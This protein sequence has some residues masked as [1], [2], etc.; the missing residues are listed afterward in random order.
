MAEAL[1][2]LVAAERLGW[3]EIQ[4]LIASLLPD[5]VVLPGYFAE[6]WSAKD[7]LAHVAGWLSEA[8]LALEQIRVGTF[9]ERAMDVEG[10]N[11]AFLAAN[12]D[13]PLSIVAAE[14]HASRQRM[15]R[16]VQLLRD[17]TDLAMVWL[18]KA[19]ADHYDEHLPRLRDWVATLRTG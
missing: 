16:E 5:Q 6:G 4:G 2:D 19:A 8:G 17:V 14:A 13:Q 7:L 15:L 1:S 10:L 9:N 3:D 11:A 12:Q 18:R